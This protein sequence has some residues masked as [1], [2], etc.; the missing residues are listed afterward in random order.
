MY[1]MTDLNESIFVFFN[2]HQDRTKKIV[3]GILSYGGT[4]SMYINEFLDEINPESTD[5]F[6]LFTSK[7]VKYLFYRYNDFFY[8]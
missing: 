6:E 4:F 1:T 8:Q 3:N 7:N 5:R 2:Q